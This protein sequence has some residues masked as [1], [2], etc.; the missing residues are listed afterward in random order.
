M[1]PSSDSS[2]HQR[3]LLREALAGSWRSLLA[4]TAFSA[5]I[6]ILLLTPVAYAL[7]IFAIVLPADS[8]QTL[9]MLTLLLV[10]LLLVTGSLV[11]VRA[12][13]LSTIGTRI[14]KRLASRVFDVVFDRARTSDGSIASTDLLNDLGRLRVFLAG[15]H[16]AG[17]CDVPWVPLHVAAMY[18]LEPRLCAVVVI[19]AIAMPAVAWLGAHRARRDSRRADDIR[20]DGDEQVRHHLRHPLV[21][22]ALGMLHGLHDR[23]LPRRD[24]SINLDTRAARNTRL[25][26]AVAETLYT[27]GWTSVLGAGAWMALHD[28]AQTGVVI[29][30]TLLAAVLLAPL[31]PLGDAL[32]HLDRT[33]AAYRRLAA[34]VS[35]VEAQAPLP[36]P[37]PSGLVSFEQVTIAPPSARDPILRHASFTIEPG[38]T[39]GVIGPSAA[40]KS[41]LLR[42]MLGLFPAHQGTIRIDG[43]TLAQWDRNLLGRHVGY[44]P[45]AV[46]LLAG[47]VGENIAR[48][49]E[50]DAGRVVAAARQADVHR[51]ILKLP[52]G[53]GT[54]LS[55]DLLSAGERQRIGLARALYGSPRL[56]LLDEPNAHLDMQGDKAL[57]RA[58][59]GLKSRGATVVIVTHRQTVLDLVDRVLVM[60]NGR[61]VEDDTPSNIIALLSGTPSLTSS[62]ARAEQPLPS[63]R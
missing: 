13:L 10:F 17:L 11:W 7:A 47:T 38:T 49:G 32:V 63:V 35:P 25:F 36:L 34:R 24:E 45:Q 3:A 19:P 27:V 14:E 6:S 44:L 39:V 59:S 61:I 22:D 41:V 48:F 4:V 43:A 46:D 54:P 1:M 33:R 60:A 8:A 37:P 26:T 52:Q 23:W 31:R 40:G 2:P 50:L 20:G 9:M 56:V 51:L 62:P 15:P 55:R 30:A 28:Q 18:W 29:A 53:Y 57:E 42:A 16:A 58:L 12:Q 21:V 5:V